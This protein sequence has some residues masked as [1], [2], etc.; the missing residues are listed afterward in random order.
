MSVAVPAGGAREG[1]AKAMQWPL[2]GIVAFTAAGV[3]PL[4]LNDYWL[5]LSTTMMMYL[6]LAASWNF[7]GGMV[8]YPSFGTA[9]FFGVGAY[10]GAMAMAANFPFWL[11]PLLGGAV[12]ALVACLIGVPILRLRGHYFAVASLAI[13]EV[14]QEIAMNWTWLTGGGMGLSIPPLRVLGMSGS[15]V[16]YFGMWA[17]ALIALLSSM[18]IVRSPL[19]V[20]FRCIRQ[21]EDAANMIGINATY[22][23]VIAFMLSAFFAGAAGAIYSSWIGYIDPTDV[24]DIINSVKPPVM[25]LLGGIGTVTGPIIGSVFYLFFEQTFWNYF[26]TFNTGLLGIIIVLLILFMPNGIRSAVVQWW[27]ARSSR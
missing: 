15:A 9:A 8:G 21:N 25:V 26:L 13:V 24:F 19:G 17:I 4:W 6:V 14:F 23:K 10:A 7:I 2:V 22:Y 11:S 27:A 16:C 12:T 18:V 20:A 3:V 5:H 1:R